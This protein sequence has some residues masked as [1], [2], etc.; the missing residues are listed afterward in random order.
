M[1][2]K[3]KIVV[4]VLLM[5]IMAGCVWNISQ[6]EGVRAKTS[7]HKLKGAG[8]NVGEI[9]GKVEIAQTFEEEKDFQGIALLAANYDREMFGTI[10]LELY[11]DETNQKLLEKDYDGKEIKNDKTNYFIFDETVKVSEPHRYRVVVSA[12]MKAFFSHFT[13]WHTG[14]D[15]YPEGALY[16]NGEEQAADLVFDTVYS[17]EKIDTLG[18]KLHRSSLVIILFAFLGLHCFLDIRKMYQWIFE[19]R[20][21]VAL[22]I[23]VFMVANKY[24]FSSMAEY[25]V[26]IETEEGS[27]Y[28]S[29][30]AGDPLAIRSD[31]W[32]VSLPRLLSAEYSNYGEYNSIVRAEKTTNLSASGLYRSYSALTQPSSWGYYLFGSEYGTSFMWCFNMV[33]GFFFSFE[34]CLILTKR[35]PLLALLGG[36]LIWFS[37]YNMWWSTVNWLLTGQAALVCF[38]YFLVTEKRWKKVLC[39]VGTA[40]FAAAFVVNLYP[41]WQV[42]AGYAYLC[43]LIWMLVDNRD[44]LKEYQWK[45]WGIG[46]VC[47]IFMISIIGIYLKND[48][49]Y[50]TD[51]MNTVYPG[52]RVSYGGFSLDRLLGYLYNFWMPFSSY[53]N[54]S[55]A[56]CFVTLF[57][58]PYLLAS[59]IF[60][61]NKKKDLLTGLLMLAATI[62]G[63]YCVFP[64]PQG[65]AKVCLLTYS[66]PG[67]VSDIVGYIMI[68]LLL[69][70]LGRYEE[71][72]KI[73]PWIAAVLTGV[74]L[75]GTLAYTQITESEYLD[76]KYYLVVAIA[77]FVVFVPIIADVKQG[78]KKTA[79]VVASVGMIA[80]G[81]LVNPLMCGLDAIYSKPVAKVIQELAEENP[82]EKWLSVAN[83]AVAG[84]FL[85]ACGAPT[86]NSV[87]YVPNMKLWE[88]LDPSGE[89]EEIYNRYAHIVVA[90]TEK[91]TSMSLRQEDVIDLS[92]SKADLKKL[93]IT[94]LYSNKKLT[95]TDSVQFKKLYHNKNAYIYQAIYQ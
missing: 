20:I 88:K 79:M 76:F 15:K 94:Y 35:K 36:S 3:I 84:N 7:S 53:K 90:L 33:F 56:G 28:A 71:R 93:D 49:E 57:P 63:L 59:V 1:K 4:F 61:K 82:N 48:A 22:G 18:M 41:A 51:V 62:L 37:S 16:I 19:K 65:V 21:W 17:Y 86:V 66:T 78:W 25:D 95:D 42:P 68:L 70:V 10:H 55:E 47:V 12:D 77:V 30:V 50:L 27:Q 8:Q 44:K 13:L 11:D 87:N 24:N 34:L 54:P 92:L 46:A 69:A 26:Y 2:K 72:A 58:I 74:V 5:I 6:Q 14:T 31:E 43:I 39:G 85:I 64:F 73:K 45:D 67:R 38:Y 75:A 29:P 52:K 60:F 91:G 9:D 89:Q 32:M 83:N 80:S 81:I 40:I 23:F